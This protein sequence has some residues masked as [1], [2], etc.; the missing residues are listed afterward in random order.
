MTHFCNFGTPLYQVS[1]CVPKVDIPNAAF[2]NIAIRD[3]VNPNEVVD[4]DDGGIDQKKKLPYYSPLISLNQIKT[5][6]INVEK[7]VF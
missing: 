6:Y 2:P 3:V 1:R 7:K 4:G 5:T